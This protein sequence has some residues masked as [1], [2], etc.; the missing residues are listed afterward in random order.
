MEN[1]HTK[2]ESQRARRENARPPGSSLA[3]VLQTKQTTS[4]RSQSTRAIRVTQDTSCTRRVLDGLV[5]LFFFKSQKT[6][7]TDAQSRAAGAPCSPR[8]LLPTSR[9]F[10]VRHRRQQRARSCA[11]PTHNP[12]IPGDGTVCEQGASTRKPVRVCLRKLGASASPHGVKT[13]VWG[14]EVSHQQADSFGCPSAK[15]PPTPPASI[16]GLSCQI[17]SYSL[18]TAGEPERRRAPVIGPRNLLKNKGR[19]D[20][21]ESN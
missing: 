16:Y 9:G 1:Q 12:D 10:F 21:S 20:W 13:T 17:R 19:P 15:P 2:K 14:G 7:G 5:C 4:L 18:P 6:R 11:A 8:S 3:S